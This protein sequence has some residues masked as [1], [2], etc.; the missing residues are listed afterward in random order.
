MKTGK[1][2]RRSCRPAFARSGADV[3]R[4]AA[5]RHACGAFFAH[6]PSAPVEY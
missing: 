1:K 4:A 2:A 5:R 3:S 6:I